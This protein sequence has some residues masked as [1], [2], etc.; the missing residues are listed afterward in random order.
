MHVDVSLALAGCAFV[1][2]RRRV[3][4]CN[5]PADLQGAGS[6]GRRRERATNVSLTDCPAGAN[7]VRGVIRPGDTNEFAS[8]KVDFKVPPAFKPGAVPSPSCTTTPARPTTRRRPLARSRPTPSFSCTFSFR[9]P[10]GTKLARLTID[11]LSLDLG[12]AI[13]K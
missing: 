10:K 2:G 6:R 8:V 9:V 12:K 3:E 7:I 13:Q 4:R 11:T 1:A 5:P